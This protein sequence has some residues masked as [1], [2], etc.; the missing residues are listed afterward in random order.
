[1]NTGKIYLKVNSKYFNQ[2]FWIENGKIVDLSIND[3]LSINKSDINI[4][5]K[6]LNSSIYEG[7]LENNKCHW[8]FDK[9]DELPLH[10]KSI[11][12]DKRIEKICWNNSLEENTLLKKDNFLI[13]SEFGWKKGSEFF[14]NYA[15][16]NQVVSL[17][18]SN[19][20]L[21]I[22]DSEF[23]EM[24]SLPAIKFKILLRIKKD[25]NSFDLILHLYNVV[26][27]EIKKQ[28]IS[29]RK[30]YLEDISKVKNT[31][32]LYHVILGT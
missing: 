17:K 4:I 5:L 21:V 22:E 12:K 10:I 15:F 20:F 2:H 24:E 1:M 11:L 3:N 18:E 26:N 19:E 13:L 29:L 7:Y 32:D 8:F 30:H 25:I 27:E 6:Q 31:F 16:N 23:K 28:G 14:N 9:Y